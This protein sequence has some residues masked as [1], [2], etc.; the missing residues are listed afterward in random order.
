MPDLQLP[1]FDSSESADLLAPDHGLRDF[2][3]GIDYAIQNSQAYDPI[4]KDI[5]FRIVDVVDLACASIEEQPQL[6]R[7]S[8]S[9]AHLSFLLDIAMRLMDEPTFRD[10]LRFDEASNG[11][12]KDR[13]NLP[14]VLEW[15]IQKF[16]TARR[17]AMA[18]AMFTTF[19]ELAHVLNGHYRFLAVRSA[20]GEAVPALTRQ[21]LEFDADSWATRMLFAVVLE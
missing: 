1:F 17:I 3:Y 10:F 8:F 6:I 7:I 14:S 19:H 13:D 5:R 18:A 11:S 2:V 12:L 16:V 9:R 21:T 4:A 20:R 15:C